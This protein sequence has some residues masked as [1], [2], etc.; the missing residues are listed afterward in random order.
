MEKGGQWWGRKVLPMIFKSGLF[1]VLLGGAR[2]GIN[3]NLAGSV[4]KS[5]LLLKL[6]ICCLYHIWK[7]EE[8]LE[9][10]IVR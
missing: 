10:K 9:G 2:K 8:S 6:V 4:R 3:Q 7:N 1:P 5:D